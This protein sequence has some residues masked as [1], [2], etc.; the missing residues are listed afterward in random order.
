MGG[1]TPGNVDLRRVTPQNALTL[2]SSLPFVGDGIGLAADA[3]S[4]ATDPST[5]TWPNALLSIASMA[6]GVPAMVGKKKAIQETAAFKKWFEG[7]K[8]VDEA[9]A[10][11]VVYHGTNEDFDRFDT[12]KS[13][14][15]IHWFGS[16]RAAIEGGEITSSYGR[17]GKKKLLSLHAALK[18]PAGWAEYEKYG[19]G[20]LKNMGYDGVILPDP[21]GSFTGF[22]FDPKKL[23]IINK[24]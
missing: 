3:Y 10:P 11:R 1:R 19:L 2:G 9:G 22:A 21:D 16:N 24:E 7:S 20:E 23:K 18:N 8:V 12:N 13:T 4:Y 5:R 15:G 14:Q 17:G 6:P